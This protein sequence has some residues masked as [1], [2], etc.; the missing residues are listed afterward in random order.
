MDLNEAMEMIA[1]SILVLGRDTCEDTIRARGHLHR[2]GLAYIYRNVELDAE[3]DA[4]NRS[5]NEGERV[6]PVILVGDPQAPSAVLVEP[7][8]EE[9]EDAI[10]QGGSAAG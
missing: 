10:R 4:W 3:A 7:S 9:L 6:T 8:D 1:P 5:Y 2:R